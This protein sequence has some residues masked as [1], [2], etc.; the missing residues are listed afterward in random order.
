MHT[1]QSPSTAEWKASIEAMRAYA[2]QHKNSL[3]RYRGLVFTDGGAPSALQRGDLNEIYGGRPIK[4]A[5]IAS[6]AF[7]RA[8]ITALTWFNLKIKAF[9]PKEV[10]EAFDH[11]GIRAPEQKQ[12]WQQLS[13]ME[14]ECGR[15]EVFRAAAMALDAVKVRKRA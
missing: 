5:V 14:A 3:D 8:V 1:T 4:V 12:L 15:V 13:E 7:V 6:S 10:L 9:A 2:E 11:I